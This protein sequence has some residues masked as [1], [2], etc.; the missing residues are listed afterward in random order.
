MS[1][2]IKTNNEKKIR[3]LLNTIYFTYIYNQT[4]IEKIENHLRE[5]NS[6]NNKREFGICL[7]QLVYK[8]KAA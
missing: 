2:S 4:Q 5:T 8:T 6:Y 3:Q 7:N 1:D